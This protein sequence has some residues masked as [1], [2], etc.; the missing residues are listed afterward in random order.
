MEVLK[1]LYHFNKEHPKCIFTFWH[2]I[3]GFLQ[4]DVYVL[5]INARRKRR[6]HFESSNTISRA[7]LYTHL[8]IVILIVISYKCEEKS[9]TFFH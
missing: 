3:I 8:A 2:E 7:A 1:A 6:F 5:E 9:C 4:A